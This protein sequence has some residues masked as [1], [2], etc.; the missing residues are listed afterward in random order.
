MRAAASIGAVVLASLLLAT[1]AHASDPMAVYAR[2]D[3][4]VLEPN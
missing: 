1:Q 2:E 3:K 4:V